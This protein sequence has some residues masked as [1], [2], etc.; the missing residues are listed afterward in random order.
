M[1][2]SGRLMD[3]WALMSE[4]FGIVLGNGEPAHQ[5]EERFMMIEELM[6]EEFEAGRT[7]FF[8]DRCFGYFR[9]QKYKD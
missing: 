6:Q 3:C 2:L 7:K 8:N 1:G 4:S 9:N 5:M